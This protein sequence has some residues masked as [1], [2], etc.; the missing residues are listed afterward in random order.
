MCGDGRTERERYVEEHRPKRTETLAMHF[1]W[2]HQAHRILGS[3]YEI[4]YNS[5]KAR[6]TVEDFKKTHKRCNYWTVHKLS[7]T[8]VSCNG[9]WFEHRHWCC[10]LEGLHM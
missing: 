8:R 7:P 4:V 2:V 5:S 6:D 1:G 9:L 10:I 3:L